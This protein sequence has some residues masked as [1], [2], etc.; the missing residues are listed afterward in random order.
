[1]HNFASIDV[2]VIF[3]L[4]KY[5]KWVT[6]SIM[7]PQKKPKKEKEK[8][9]EKRKWN[10]SRPERLFKFLWIKVDGEIRKGKGITGS[11]CH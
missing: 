11:F 6:F 5:A 2:S 4:S 7:P 3:F 10:G 9:K 1:M 8:E